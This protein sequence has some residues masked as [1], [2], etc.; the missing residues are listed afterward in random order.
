MAG[1]A[2]LPNPQCPGETA[3]QKDP[4]DEVWKGRT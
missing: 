1:V 4:E 2:P 3:L